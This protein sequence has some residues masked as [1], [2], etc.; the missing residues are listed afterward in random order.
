MAYDLEE[1]EKL[2]AL[3]D[4]WAKYGTLIVLLVLAAALS[5]AG[6]RGWQWYQG[7]KA[8]Q[9][10]GYFEAL[11]QAAERSDDESLERVRTASQT[12]R[13]DFSSSGYTPRGMLLAASALQKNGD[14]EDA[15]EQL[16]WV[17]EHSTDESL[18]QLARLRMGGLL[19]DKGD[20]DEALDQLDNPPKAFQALY[21]DRRG[22]IFFAQGEVDKARDEWQT[23]LDNLGDEPL[24]QIVQLKLD[25]LNGA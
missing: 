10:M 1:Q 23:A 11:E 8:S 4:W 6:W 5:V 14:T 9:A 19:L 24:A 13:D 15:I 22:D 2:D 12:L 7:H 25:A 3:R 17:A 21:A 20:Y 16:R 18:V